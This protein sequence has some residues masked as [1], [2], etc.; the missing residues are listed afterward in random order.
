MKPSNLP[1]SSP[2]AR[3]RNPVVFRNEARVALARRA[4]N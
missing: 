2:D 4:A 1:I 3:T